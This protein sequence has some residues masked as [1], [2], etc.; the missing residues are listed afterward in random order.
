MIQEQ[1][2]KVVMLHGPATAGTAATTSAR[3]DT[4]G[5]RY[6]TVEGVLPKATATNSSAK[7]GVFKLT[8]ADLTTVSSASALVTFTGTTNSVT[9]ATNGYVIAA[10]NDTTLGQVTRLFVDCKARK[11]YLFVTFQAA[12]S[13]STVVVKCDLGRAEE[14]PNTDTKRGVGVSAIG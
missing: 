4:L 9:D 11:R 8:E 5:F 3:I 1:N 7:W 10:H 2:A 12:D 14:M 6:C 13:H